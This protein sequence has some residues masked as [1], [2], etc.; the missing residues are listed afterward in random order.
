[1]KMNLS[2]S[3]RARREGFSV[4]ELLVAVSVLSVIVY[5]LFSVF[6]QTQ[7]ALRSNIAQVDVLESGRAA[8]DLL[9][10]DVFE[11]SATPA[12]AVTESALS[13]SYPYQI[14]FFSLLS[15]RSARSPQGS[16]FPPRPGA[17]Q[18]RA[19]VYP[20]IE[21]LMLTNSLRRTNIVQEM[22]FMTH[23]GRD[24]RGVGYRV[25]PDHTRTN[26]P[27]YRDREVRSIYRHLGVAREKEIASSNRNLAFEFMRATPFPE[28]DPT[29]FFKIADGIVHFKVTPVDFKG[30][31]MRYQLRSTNAAPP[32][33]IPSNLF[34]I[35]PLYA[36]N[37]YLLRDA[38]DS[39]TAS[40]FILDALPSFVEIE[41][42]VLDSATVEKYY[43]IPDIQQARKF[44]ERQAGKVHLFRQRIPIR[45]GNR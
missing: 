2:I 43:S 6:N 16:P 5:V 1:M 20:A 28:N 32:R 4:I 27:S 9:V 17:S 23:R 37:V 25:M 24:W 45:T 10:R 38:R 39:E 31:E 15:P 13:P 44:L 33:A 34:T 30:R 8:M 41:L 12:P 42:G 21:Q 35:D 40:A 22:F 11:M 19:D 29:N 18:E 14:N 36:T 7:K 3:W 26:D